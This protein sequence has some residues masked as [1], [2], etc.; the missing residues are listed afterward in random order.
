MK[1]PLK[2]YVAGPLF[3]SGN[4]DDNIRAALE[5]GHQ[6]RELGAVPVI[7][8]LFF[9]WDLIF[10]RPRE[11]WM[12][13]DKDLVEDCD[14]T[15]RLDGKSDGA[16][17]EEGWSEKVFYERNKLYDYIMEYNRKTFGS[18]WREHDQG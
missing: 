7:P 3:S 16:D 15:L 1:K 17:D 8:H 14:V 11:Y 12:A 9:F 13:L 4:I 18:V 5:V 6:I 2:V 10:P